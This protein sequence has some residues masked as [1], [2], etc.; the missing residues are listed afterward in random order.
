M[1]IAE[2]FRPDFEYWRKF[3]ALS[4]WEITYLMIGVDPRLAADYVVEDREEEPMHEREIGKPKELRQRGGISPCFADIKRQLLDAVAVG[5]LNAVTSLQGSDPRSPPDGQVKIDIRTLR[6]WLVENGFTELAR[7][8]AGRGLSREE[9]ATILL[10]RLRELGGRPIRTRE[11]EWRFDG[12]GR[13]AKDLVNAGQ[14][15]DVKT[16][17]ARLTEAVEREESSR[18][19]GTAESSPAEKPIAT[20]FSGLGELK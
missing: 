6:P 14:P 19:E 3:P 20:P 9:S 10:A 4:V 13:L 11:G 1:P 8:L 18:R 12:I 7:E 5:T 15:M 17:R 2:H 16:I